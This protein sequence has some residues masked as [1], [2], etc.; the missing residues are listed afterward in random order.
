MRYKL[1]LLIFSLL[2]FV[3]AWAQHQVNTGGLSPVA[4]SIFKEP[5]S[6][7]QLSSQAKKG[8]SNAALKLGYIYRLGYKVKKDS[9]K[10]VE[11]FKKSADKGNA[12]GQ[13]QMAIMS[14]SG[15]GTAQNYEQM[16]Y[17]LEKSAEN[18]YGLSQF[19]L[20]L[21]YAKG[22]TVEQDIPV[23]KMW[24]G[25]AAEQPGEVGQMAKTVLNNLREEAQIVGL[26]YIGNPLWIELVE[27]YGKALATLQLKAEQKDPHGE[28]L[29]GQVFR[30]LGDL[31]DE[32]NAKVFYQEAIQC[33]KKAAN[34][35]HLAAT[36]MLGQMIL[37]GQSTSQHDGIA[38]LTKA[39]EMGFAPAQVSLGKW[40]LNHDKE[41]AKLWLEQ[42]ASKNNGY[43]KA[44]LMEDEIL[45][46]A[47]NQRNLPVK[48]WDARDQYVMAQAYEK[49]KNVALDIEQAVAWYQMAA[50]QLLV[51]AQRRYGLALLHG[52]GIEKN[53]AEALT[54]LSL[55]A[56]QGDAESLLGLADLALAAGNEKEAF[57]L[58]EKAAN[59]GLF[60]AQKQLAI[61]YRDG[62]GVSQNEEEAM[63]WFEEANL[64]SSLA[65]ESVLQIMQQH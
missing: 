19:Q 22:I 20:G 44:F 59:Q 8:D 7:N 62:K 53:E 46:T 33:F 60:K 16:R 65:I 40:Y 24:L 35:N 43:A 32:T 49:G 21:L 34:Q 54:W 23:A 4:M 3:P 26:D 57:S 12:E 10:A 56:E 11:W 30:W 27:K 41:K 50:S 58:Y 37:E 29:L 5:F 25:F 48:K 38:W 13:L 9:K 45:S 42:A 17:W 28:Y 36:Y 15:E 14:A 6:V 61:L 1:C 18:G 31:S 47:P 39:A 52:K 51:P 63:K 2:F 64:Q 55:A